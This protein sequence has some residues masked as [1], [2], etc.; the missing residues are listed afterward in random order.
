MRVNLS[1]LAVVTL[2]AGAVPASA[3]VTQYECRFPAEHARGGGWVPEILVLWEDD[4]NGKTL[5]F[6]PII[7]EFIGEPIE[8]TLSKR[9]AARSTYRWEVK[10]QNKGQSARMMYTFS[11]LSNGNTARLTV[12]PGGYDN[13]WSGDGTCKVSKG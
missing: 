4:Q 5:A 10:M 6:D 9:T 12:R 3:E 1:A 11:Y 8:V 13:S 2:I 7:K